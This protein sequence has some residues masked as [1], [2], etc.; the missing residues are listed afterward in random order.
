MKNWI[1]KWRAKW[2]NEFIETLRAKYAEAAGKIAE[3]QVLLEYAELRLETIDAKLFWFQWENAMQRR[4]DLKEQL[5]YWTGMA[6][7]YQNQIEAVG[8]A[9]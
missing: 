2:R 8:G 5:A 7:K 1:N 9:A 4:A 3:T 6:G